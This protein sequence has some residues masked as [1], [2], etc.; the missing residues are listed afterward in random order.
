MTY[1]SNSLFVAGLTIVLCL[2][3]AVPAGYGLARFKIPGKEFWFVLLLAPLMIPY[4]ALLT[5][6][7]LTFSKIGLANSHFG[8]AIVHTIL[9]LPFSI[10]LMRNSFEA[11][12]QELEEAAMIDGS[13]LVPGAA[14]H[15]PAA[16]RSRRS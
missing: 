14:A 4:Q 13:V 2:A 8:L 15:L 11:I 3:L 7:Y 10:Y 9:Q 5:P 6:L 1:A 12:P 16:G